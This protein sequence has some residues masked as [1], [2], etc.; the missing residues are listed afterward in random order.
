MMDFYEHKDFACFGVAGNFTGHLEQAGEDKDFLKLKVDDKNAPKAVFPTFIPLSDNSE[1]AEKIA[2]DDATTATVAG[3]VEVPSF[4]RIFPFSSEKIIFPVGEKKLQIESECAVL[5]DA[6]WSG[7]NPKKI[8]SL[9]PVGF[10]ASNDCSI[11][12]EGAKKISVK[13]NWGECS[14][15]LS[16]N[17][18]PLQTFSANCLLDDY[19]IASFLVRDK[20]IYVY[21]EDSPVRTYSYIYEKLLH[22]LL[23]KFNFQKDEGPAEDIAS[24]LRMSGCPSKIMVSV[25]ATRYTDFGE[26]NFLE[27][28]D[29]SCVIL[30]PESKYSENEI[31][32]LLY[33]V[34]FLDGKFEPSISALIQT[35]VLPS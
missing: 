35:V 20:K 29:K 2:A 11:R 6:V 12:R 21:G 33:D 16:E 8:S 25:G 3:S 19:R 32:K 28:G 27:D 23:D 14:K 17:I 9:N 22:W 13:K 7:E 31:E 1:S 34:L 10:A 24:Y 18:I 30:Y 4:L 15:G 5:F 26:R